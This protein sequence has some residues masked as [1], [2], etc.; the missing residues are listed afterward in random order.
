MARQARKNT[1][2]VENVKEINYRFHTSSKRTTI[3]GYLLVCHMK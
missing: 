1:N 2:L 3:N